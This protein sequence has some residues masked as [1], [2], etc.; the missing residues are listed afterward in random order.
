MVGLGGMVRRRPAAFGLG[1]VLVVITLLNFKPDFYLVGWDNYS[2]Y[3]NL[4]DGIWRTFWATWREYRGLGVSSDAE[5]ADLWRQLFFWLIHWVVPERWLDQIYYLLGLWLGVWGMYWLSGEVLKKRF[6]EKWQDLLGLVASGAYLFNLN[7][8]SIFYSPMIPFTNRFW[9]LPWLLYLSM[10]VVRRKDRSSLIWWIALVVLSS[11]SY[12]T[13]TVLITTVMAMAIFGL[14]SM[15]WKWTLGLG[16]LFLLLN[17]FW[18]LPFVNYTREKSAIVPLS[19]T[20]VE[21]NENTLNRKAEVFSWE[22][23]LELYPSFLDMS[24]PTIN[25]ES[26]DIH[27]QLSEYKEGWGRYRLWLFPILYL[28][29]CG[30]LLINWRRDKKLGWILAWVVIFLFLSMREYGP[31]GVVYGWLSD[32]ILYFRVIFRISDTKFHTYIGLAGAL[33]VAYGM[34]VLGAVVKKGWWLVI[35]GLVTII[36]GYGFRGYFNGNLMGYFVYNQVPKAYGEMAKIINQDSRD[37]RVMHL[38]MDRVAS[39]WRPFTWGYLGS[40]FF[41]FMINK[42]YIDKTFEPAS[43]ENAYL[44]TRINNLIDE[45]FFETEGEK[46]QLLAQRFLSLLNK[47]GVGYVI[48]DDS[49]SPQIYA[50]NQ[51]YNSKQFGQRARQLMT[52]LEFDGVVSRVGSYSLSSREYEAYRGMYPVSVVGVPKIVPEEVVIDL[53]RVKEVKP[54][55]EVVGEA[56]ELD[57]NFENGLETGLMEDLGWWRQSDEGGATLLPFLNE[58]HGVE[59]KEHEIDLSYS[60]VENNTYRVVADASMLDS[61]MVEVWGKV[62]DKK[63]VVT[64]YH[65]YLPNINGEEF[66]KLAGETIFKK[67]VIGGQ[68]L[69]VEGTVLSIPKNI[70]VEEVKLGTVVVHSQNLTVKLLTGEESIPQ[71]MDKFELTTPPQ[72]YGPEVDDYQGRVE[73]RGEELVLA[74]TRGAICVEQGWEKK[75]AEYEEIM[76]RLVREGDGSQVKVPSWVYVCVSD[77]GKCINN[78]QNLKLLNGENSYVIPVDSVQTGAEVRLK[79][80]LIPLGNQEEQVGVVALGRKTFLEQEVVEVGLTIDFPEEQ[81][82]V[83]TSELVIGIPKVSGMNTDDKEM[84]TIPTDGC[85]NKQ[86]RWWTDKGLLFSQIEG[87]T[88]FQA[89]PFRYS[90]NLA[91]LM[92]FNYWLGEG[93][94]PHIVIGYQGDDYLVER[95]S[96]NQK[97]LEVKSGFTESQK[98]VGASRW[99]GS[100]LRTGLNNQEAFAHIFQDTEGVGR[101]GVGELGIWEYPKAWERLAIVPVSPPTKYVG[102]VAKGV[103]E[104]RRILPSWWQVEMDG[105]GNRMLAFGQAYDRQW[106]VYQG[107]KRVGTN[108]RCNGWQNCF[109]LDESSGGGTYQIIYWPELLSLAGWTLTL[110][111]AILAPIWWR[112]SKKAAAE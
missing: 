90:S 43:M 72:C 92:A 86:R 88:V 71:A 50:R 84:L 69:K 40:A 31:G 35:V 14:I 98:P 97:Y 7:T 102:R 24:F 9:G 44:D 22:K 94:Q 106:G 21:I 30:L 103:V 78:W 77:G 89:K 8:L 34:G 16:S 64:W 51:Y 4:K 17:A 41:D 26:V 99:L 81:I 112:R 13:P 10:R 54:M 58:N 36:Y 111:S 32:N 109:K 87:C 60:G 37:G 68:R 95:V 18:I 47:T 75:R 100:G 70:G 55:V 39:Y 52:A 56:R 53:Y 33:A 105:S 93:Q 48:V 107:G 27:P 46:K 12:V 83:A 65:R 91:Y 45:H 49:I 29:G 28:I 25:G 80:G 85:G 61:F 76:V 101:M 38:P 5:V 11:G 57:N 15:G 1:V 63:L 96:L 62:V 2:S 110:G 42:P 6:G 82:Q 20:F 104:V 59:I 67:E 79:L 66:R 3:F 19:R 73:K 108:G 23:Q 74:S